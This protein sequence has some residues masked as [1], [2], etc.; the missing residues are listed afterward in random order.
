[1]FVAAPQPPCV[2]LGRS[3]SCGRPVWRP[4]WGGD[5]APRAMVGVR[6]GIWTGCFLPQLPPWGLQ[7]SARAVPGSPAQGPGWGACGHWSGG[8]K[9]DIPTAS[10]QIRAGLD[11]RGWVWG[12]GWPQPVKTHL[13]GRTVCHS[14]W[15]LPAERGGGCGASV[16][17]TQGGSVPPHPWG[18]LPNP[19]PHLHSSVWTLGDVLRAAGAPPEPP[20]L[21]GPQDR[22]ELL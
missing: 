8:P 19:R 20:R 16:L 14:S 4:G 9:S 18:L 1:M 6:T 17:S 3:L 21:A 12:G 10:E 13:S 7:G 11:A 5:Q 15:G 2:L 22:K